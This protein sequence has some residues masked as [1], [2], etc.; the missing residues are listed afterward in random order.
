MEYREAARYVAQEFPGST[1]IYIPD[2]TTFWGIARYLVGPDWGSILAVQDPERSDRS[3]TWPR[4]YAR[5]GP[6]W[7][8][9]LGL[10]PETRY[11]SNGAMTLAIGLSRLPDDPAKRQ[12]VVIGDGGIDPLSMAI[13]S[14]PAVSTRA[15]RGLLVLAVTCTP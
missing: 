2:R 13:C 10:L 11:V 9:R 7:L 4:L 6:D 8:R 3:E 12:F 15:F 5:I 14:S 1:L